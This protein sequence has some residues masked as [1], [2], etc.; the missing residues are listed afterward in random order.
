MTTLNHNIIN[1]FTDG[2]CSGNPGEGGT[3]AILTYNEHEKIITGYLPLTTNNQMELLGAIIGLR[4]LKKASEVNL[5]TDSNYLKNGMTAWI[6]NWKKNNWRSS[7]KS[8]VKNKELWLELDKLANIHTINWHWI[9]GHAGH[10]YNE[11]ADYWARSA[12]SNKAP[13]LEE[14]LFLTKSAKE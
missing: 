14:F 11:K 10:E 12:I 13:L 6:F 2:A 1:I 3:C 9:K 7:N 4:S 8:P 5:Y